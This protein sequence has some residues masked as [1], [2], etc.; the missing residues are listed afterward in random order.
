MASL[1]SY[2]FHDAQIR[3]RV[4]NRLAM[5]MFKNMSHA[6]L[7]V[8]MGGGPTEIWAPQEF[9]GVGIQTSEQATIT[10]PPRGGGK[11]DPQQ[12]S[13]FQMNM[14]AVRVDFPDDKRVTLVVPRS[15]KSQDPQ[16]WLPPVIEEAN[17][18]ICLGED[19]G[20]FE[21]D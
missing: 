6:I 12:M 9:E 8:D 2:S 21:A 18:L 3:F 20:V 17:R 4:E 5:S 1:D 19:V 7:S 10:V 11:G 13:V 15:Y 14:I 16:Q